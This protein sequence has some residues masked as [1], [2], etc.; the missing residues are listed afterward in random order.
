[1]YCFKCGE[2]IVEDSI[3]C[4]YCGVRL[5]FI[6]NGNSPIEENQNAEEQI[7]RLNLKI[8]AEVKEYLTVRAAQES[9]KRQ[10][11]I[12]LTNYL[13][14]IIRHD[15]DSSKEECEPIF[16]SEPPFNFDGEIPT[17]SIPKYIEKRS[18][19]VQIVLQP[20]LYERAKEKA[21]IYGKSFNDY[22]HELIEA[23][24]PE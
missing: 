11:K 1:M 8:P 4:T 20:S 21:E 7:E 6:E 19:R 23:D 13:L 14:E 9:I 12:S 22:I 18:R 5:P 17:D 2:E 3:Y 15:M 10:T 16:P 24:S